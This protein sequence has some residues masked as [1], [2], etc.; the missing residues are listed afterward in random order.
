[1]NIE[2]R[3]LN[4]LESADSGKLPL[5]PAERFG[6]GSLLIAILLLF[7]DV[8]LSIIPSAGFILLC[9]AAPFF[10]RFGFYLPVISRGVS[11]KKAVALTF[12]DGPDPLVTPQV[13]QLLLK[14]QVKAT[15][16]VTGKKAAEHPELIKE[17]LLH[18]HSIGN[19]S[20][21]HDN[22]LMFRRIKTIANEI[23]SAQNVLSDFGIV[24]LAFRPPVGI[25]GPRLRPAL[26]NSGMYIVN[27]SCRAYDGG[28]R[29]IKN[30]SKKILKRARP[31]DIVV[32]HDV[33]P[34]KQSLFTYWLNEMDL[35]VSGLK[36]KGLAVL[37]LAEIIGR[38]VMITKTGDP[39]KER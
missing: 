1:M 9:A 22:L 37:P 16:F 35:I 28:N 14:H 4:S 12:D 11:N 33:R 5:S 27:F 23:E 26:L 20:Y 10:P 30:I 19:H 38:P 32:L 24:P 15:F 36:E 21:I 6:I 2:H 3:K 25:T 18:G 7:F 8:R 31:G 13:L 17:I 29:W 39:K 34:H